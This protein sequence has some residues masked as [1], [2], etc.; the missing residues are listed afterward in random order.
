MP[1][2]ET[3]A[4]RVEGSADLAFVD[5][6]LDEVDRLWEKAP[7]V[8][9]DDRLLFALAVSEIATNIVEHSPPGTRIDALVSAAPSALSA[10]L[11]DTAAPAH[12]DLAGAA[13]PD[14]NA[15]SGRG[16][17]LSRTVLDEL[18]HT[19]SDTGNAWRMVRIIRPASA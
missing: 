17:A 10:E 16:L 13:M 19:G 8:P 4:I 12:I 9:D 6:L 1:T 15:E 5:S 2:D 3:R 18:E 11:R 7:A 14:A